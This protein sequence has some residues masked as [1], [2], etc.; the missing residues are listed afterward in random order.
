MV[1][2]R[3]LLKR[4]AITGALMYGWRFGPPT[5]VAREG[6]FLVM[7]EHEF[8]VGDPAGSALHWDGSNLFVR[9]EVTA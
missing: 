7:G 5:P 6:C 1:T 8:R 9:G 3:A 4:L 2:R